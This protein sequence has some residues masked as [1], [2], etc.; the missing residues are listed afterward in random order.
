MTALIV[1]IDEK[2]SL[3]VSQANSRK[4]HTSNTLSKSLF[5]VLGVR[6]PPGSNNHYLISDEQS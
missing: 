5:Y 3:N 6:V 1:V 4:S 2:R